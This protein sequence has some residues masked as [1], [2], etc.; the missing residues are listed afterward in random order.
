MNVHMSK[1]HFMFL[2]HMHMPLAKMVYF[3]TDMRKL[4]FGHADKYYV[5]R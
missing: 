3:R 5:Y 1:E 4:D 2:A